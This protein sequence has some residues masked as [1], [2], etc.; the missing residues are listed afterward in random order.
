MNPSPRAV[1]EGTVL[2][3]VE[4]IK[5]NIEMGLAGVREERP[6]GKVSTEIPKDYFIYEM[7][8]GY[9]VPAVFVIGD[10]IDFRLDRGQN[11]INAMVTV[12]VSVLVDDRNAELLAYKMWRYQ[13][14]LHAI[15][16][17]AELYDQKKE[18]KNVIKVTKAEFSNTFQPKA[19]TPGTEKNPF[20][21]EVMLTLEVE[22][23]EKR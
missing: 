15:L 17:Q 3:I 12:Y 14:A 21:K 1:M 22:H 18:I 16:D 23:W 13:D 20:R 6:D 8:I 9:K 11:F 7:A 19:Q 5:A 4:Y 2:P 10:T